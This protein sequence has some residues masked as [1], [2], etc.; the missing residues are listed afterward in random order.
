MG[1]QRWRK[2]VL[3]LKELRL[4]EELWDPGQDIW[5]YVTFSEDFIIF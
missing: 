4:I 3:I 1:V 5:I 2:R